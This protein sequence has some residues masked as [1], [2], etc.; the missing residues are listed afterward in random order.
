MHLLRI[1]L[2]EP[3]TSADEERVPCENCAI[4]AVG[5][6]IADAVLGVAGGVQGFDVDGTDV[7]G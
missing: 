3:S 4:R 5:E 7:E 2:E 6:E 1:T